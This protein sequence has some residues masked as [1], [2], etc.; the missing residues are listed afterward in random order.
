MTA[1]PKLKIDIVSDVVCPWCVVGYKN[2]EAALVELQGE[3]SVDVTWHPFELNPTMGPAG[4]EVREHIAEKYG[5]SAADSNGTRDRISQMGDA[6][7][8]RFQWSDGMRIYNT[9]DSHRLLAWAKSFDKQQAL[10]MALFEHYF[11]ENRA[12]NDTEA[13]IACAALV[14]LDPILAR[15]VLSTDAYADEVRQELA[16]YRSMGIQSVPTFVINDRYAITGG[17]P[18][19]VFVES[20]R[21]IANEPLSE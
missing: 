8:F 20:L 15:Q 7:G 13:L 4:Q 18:A 21:Q 10:Q 5:S 11:S 16:H 12:L 6:V 14:G 1:I 19:A 9:F 2:L 3:L 17:Q